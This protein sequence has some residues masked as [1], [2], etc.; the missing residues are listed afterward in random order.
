MRIAVLGSGGIGGYYGALRAKAGHDVSFVA[1]GAH[2]EAMQ[3]R[4]VEAIGSVV[5]AGAVLVG[6][7]TGGHSSHAAPGRR[8]DRQHRFGP[9]PEGRPRVSG[10]PVRRGEGR[11]GDAHEDDRRALR[12]GRHP[13]QLLTDPAVRK[14]ME[15]RVPLGRLGRPDEIAQAVLHL[16]SDEAAWTTGAILTVDGGIMAQ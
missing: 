7:V 3:G 4:G 16:A 2:L 5:G 15:G 9:R 6:V 8:L 10:P 12:E 14:A 1:R 11:R 13:L